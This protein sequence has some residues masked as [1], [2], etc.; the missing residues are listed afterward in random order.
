MPFFRSE[1]PARWTDGPRV[2]I[3][4]PYAPRKGLATLTRNIEWALDDAVQVFPIR[5]LKRLD[6]EFE[7][8]RAD[9]AHPSLRHDR[10]VARGTSLLSWLE[11]L[12]LLICVERAVPKL[13]AHCRERGIRTAVVALPDWIAG[14]AAERVD[15]LSGAH[16][17]VVYG[18][19]AGESLRGDGLTNVRALPLALRD[20]VEAPRPTGE[21]ITF[22]FNI[23]SGGPTDRRHVPL[24]LDTFRAV[25]P[26]HRHARFLVKVHPSARKRL[27]KLAALHPQMRV[28]DRELSRDE[29]D[30][31]QRSVDVTLFPTRFEGVGYP[32]LESLHAG[33][34][35]IT[36]DAPPMN[37]MVID[38]EN[39]LLTK[40][41]VVGRFGA[42]PRWEIA[43]A[44]LRQQLERCLREPGLVDRLK[45]GAGAGRVEA[46]QAFRE[47]WRR[48]VSELGPRRLNLGAGD[49][50]HA[51][52]WNLDIRRC[53]GT[54]VLA[55]AHQLPFA[56]A[57]LDEVLAQDLLEHFPGAETDAL[58]AE[59]VRVLRPG[60]TLRVQ[61]PDIRALAQ[62]LLRGKLSREKTIEWLYGGQDHPY[63]FHQTGFDEVKLRERLEAQGIQDLRRVERRVSSKNVCLEGRRAR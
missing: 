7:T 41:S 38:G 6:G 58:L 13:C 50:S 49:D 48:L 55:D 15:T 25:L 51:A 46:A 39:G 28:I 30:A 8:V 54:D 18:A 9:A 2:G 52:R 45:A 12:D 35:V 10:V 1:Q 37:E 23:G 17:C 14:S 4:S 26:D 57:S 56:D 60:G 32:I 31:L 63:N 19:A 20:P 27:G 53:A 40:A 21:E 36:T 24:V 59:W 5:R 33:V 62:S 16:A 43:P 44:S 42:L 47:G 3:V 29:M 61:T 34:P 11:G 22:Y